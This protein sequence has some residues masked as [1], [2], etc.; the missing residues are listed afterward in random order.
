MKYDLNRFIKAQE[1]DF[2]NALKEIKNGYKVTH[3]MWYIFPQLKDLGSSSMAIYYGIDGKE[4][5]I[6]YLKNDYLRNN[7]LVICKSLL[8]LES[9]DIEYILGY[10][11]NLKLQSSMTLFNYVNPKEK[12]YSEVLKK[13]YNNE[14][15]SKTLHLLEK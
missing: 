6:E 11:D 14:L 12:T 1:E 5:A 4:E 10:P 15:D 7:L 2:D 3:W 9:N 8:E 13:Y